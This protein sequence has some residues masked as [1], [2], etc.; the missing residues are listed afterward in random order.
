MTEPSGD[1]PLVTVSVFLFGK[2]AWEIDGLEGSPV[3][4]ILLSAIA[5]CGQELSRRLTRAAELGRMLVVKGWEGYGLLY[6]VEFYKEVTL[7]DAE[8]ELKGLGIEPDEVSIREE[9]ED[10]GG[11]YGE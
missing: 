4:M 6:E 8:E 11:P 2:P 9:S 5:S 7:T 10:S 3:D 1:K